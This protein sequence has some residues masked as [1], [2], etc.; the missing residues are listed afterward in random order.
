M[1]FPAIKHINDVLP[2]I[3]GLEHIQVTRKADYIVIDYNYSDG[4]ASF[5][6]PHSL[7]CR[8]LKF[9]LL[10][11]II[12]RPLHKFFNVGEDGIHPD[13]S[14]EHEVLVKL[15]GSMIHPAPIGG[16]NRF[17]TRGGITDVSQTAEILFPDILSRCGALLDRRI[18]PIF[19]YVGPDNRIVVRY[20]RAELVL[21]AARET[22]SGRYLRTSELRG[23]VNELSGTLVSP[24]TGP[25]ERVV[26]L[27]GVEG[28][29]LAF[30][31]GFRAK[32]KARD[33][34]LRH[35]ARDNLH[36]ER[37]A[38][39]LVL[40]QQVD[41]ISTYLADKDFTA[42][43][44]YSV[45][46]HEYV[47]TL[48]RWLSSTLTR[49]DNLSRKEIA[50]NIKTYPKW[51]QTLLFASLAAPLTPSLIFEHIARQCTRTS[52]LKDFLAQCEKYPIGEQDDPFNI[53]PPRWKDY[54]AAF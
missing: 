41:D 32:I 15:N 36:R 34:V 39:L 23:L 21:I 54:Y 40:N 42:L 33:Y 51:Q 35:R 31:D 26:D 52:R 46:I 30:P 11:N 6:N 7:E 29:V 47:R 24:Y 28:V 22:I 18:T 20:D 37:T 1:R 48:E 38:L 13:L 16:A 53:F 44:S 49:F 50:L 2:H 5:P 10:G 27:K 19:E 45:A 17:M 9:N 25:I 12:A 14:Q 4:P 43:E 8:G 3:A